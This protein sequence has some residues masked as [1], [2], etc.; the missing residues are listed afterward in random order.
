MAA[1]V[2]AIQ[3]WRSA[4][5]RVVFL[6]FQNTDRIRDD[7][8]IFQDILAAI[9][10]TSGPPI[11]IRRPNADA[12]QIANALA[13]IDVFTGMR[14]HGLVL[15]AMLG[16]P[17]VGL[18]HDDKIT[19]ICR[20]FQMPCIN[21]SDLD[22]ADLVSKVELVRGRVPDQAVLTSCVAAAQKNFQAFAECNR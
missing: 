3:Q 15:A 18:A 21:V 5:T 2:N 13:D 19:E 6:V 12:H 7:N 9:A 17:F 4:G 14:Y 10:A 11:E 22:G 1:L 16:L 20:R 8:Q